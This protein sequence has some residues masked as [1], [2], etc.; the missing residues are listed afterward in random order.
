MDKSKVY[1]TNLRTKPGMSL[2]KK[3]RNLVKAAGIENI[4]FEGQYTAIKLHFGEPGNMAYIRPNYVATVV[5]LLN[6][7]GAKTFL[8]DANTLYKGRRDNAV[9]HLKSAMVNGFNPI[10]VNCNVII[11]DGLKGTN[12]AAIPVEGAKY[13]RAPK[14]GQAVADA[15]III[16]MSHFKGHEQAGF[17]GAL[18]NLGMGCASIAGKLELHSSSQP[19]VNAKK[20]IGCKIC[21][22]N[23]NHSAITVGP[24]R[25]AVIDYEKC[26]GCGQ[27]VALC[28]YEGAVLASWDTSEVL[29]YK[30]A[31]YTKAVLKDKPNF[32]ISF[33]MNV[34]PEC[35]CWGHNDIAIVPDLGMLASFDPVALDQACADLVNSAPAINGWIAK[36][37]APQ[38]AAPTA[39]SAAVTVPSAAAIATSVAVTAPSAAATA[40]S[41]AATST[42][43]AVTASSADN[44]C[45][46]HGHN[47]VGHDAVGHEAACHDAV[48]HEAAPEDKF[49]IIHPDTDWE[50]GLR[51]A[52]ELGLGNREYELITV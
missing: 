8:T 6:S 2:L 48:A 3:L 32:H 41:V 31:E 47:A 15:D 24:D 39:T 52:Q 49:K 35:D 10:Q 4:N 13:C 7:L 26:V 44:C 51:Y 17:G 22:K 28:Q 43:A 30:I 40:T 27:C 45:C 34:S 37:P 36:Q 1:Y 14:I 46:H 25:L 9:D 38:A 12:Y 21:E 42:S 5:D 23:C 29:N 11:A 18:K 19:K 50:A 20:C 16:S 33:I